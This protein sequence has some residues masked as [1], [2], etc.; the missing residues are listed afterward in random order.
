MSFNITYKIHDKYTKTFEYLNLI[1][2][3]IV[4][5]RITTNNNNSDAYG[6]VLNNINNTRISR[7]VVI[8]SPLIWIHPGYNME[9]VDIIVPPSTKWDFNLIDTS[10]NTV[11]TNYDIDIII[12]VKL[13]SNEQTSTH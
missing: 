10:G 12:T 11:S 7:N 5:Q 3:S 2:S 1:K 9:L 4:I 6:L 13:L 8:E